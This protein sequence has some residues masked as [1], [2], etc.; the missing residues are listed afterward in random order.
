[1]QYLN[2]ANFFAKKIIW[3]MVKVICDMLHHCMHQR[4]WINLC[5]GIVVHKNRFSYKVRCHVKLWKKNFEHI[6][7]EK[8][9]NL[10]LK[11]NALTQLNRFSKFEENIHF[12]FLTSDA[13]Y[14][15]V[16]LVVGILQQF[17]VIFWLIALIYFTKLR[18]RW[19]FWGALHVKILIGSKGMTENTN[20]FISVFLPFWKT[21]SWKVISQKKPF[22]DHFW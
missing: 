9:W 3:K 1:M 14:F 17:L 10:L 12:D 19:S 11:Y 15:I 2:C 20:F 8:W 7:F 5:N 21:K 16:D 18:F 13:R 4:N 22:K 6:L